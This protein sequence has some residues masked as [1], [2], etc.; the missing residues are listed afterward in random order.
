M[1]KNHFLE[2]RHQKEFISMRV[3]SLS[4]NIL[5]LY[6][7]ITE[8]RILPAFIAISLLLTLSQALSLSHDHENRHIS[9]SKTPKVF[10]DQ[11]FY[12]GEIITM[13]PNNKTV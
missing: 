13:G 2:S 3:F 11:V 10:A 7:W 4:E 5:V 12:N 8:M 9:P 1:S 6:Y